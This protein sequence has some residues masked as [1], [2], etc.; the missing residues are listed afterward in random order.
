MAPQ[1]RTDVSAFERKLARAQQAAAA[2]AQKAEDAAWEETDKRSLKKMA[3]ANDLAL[4]ADNKLRGKTERRQS[5]AEEEKRLT[6]QVDNKPKKLTVFEI[7][8][9]K[10]LMAAI[11]SGPGNNDVVSVKLRENDNRQRDGISASGINAAL[12]ALDDLGSKSQRLFDEVS[13]CSTLDTPK[14]RRR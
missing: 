1:V 3:R 5:L 6:A 7:E 11:E 10:A 8:R 14:P 4:K 13:D 12:A 9:R 2:A